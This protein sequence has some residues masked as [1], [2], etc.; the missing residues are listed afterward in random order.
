[1][2]AAP[3]PGLIHIDGR[4]VPFRE[5]QTVLQAALAA[6][7]V[8]PH[9]C[10]RPELG[11]IG[12]CRLCLVETE[13]RT[14]SACT[15]PAADGQA[16]QSD[17]PVLRKLRSALVQMLLEQGTHACTRC[18]RT[19]DCRLQGAAVEL[20]VPAVESRP[21]L[22]VSPRDDSHPQVALDRGRCILCSICIQASRQLDGKNLFAFSG[23]GGAMSLTVE[24]ASGL[25]RDS[26][27]NADDHAVR[28]CP[29]GSLTVK[30]DQAHTV[31]FSAYDFFDTEDWSG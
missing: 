5:G 3:T 18:E 30:K 29:T 9:L 20:K 7:V 12:S 10:Y 16:V 19:G 21:S 26:A 31:G 24:S 25:L 2:D 4:T 23:R 14:L 1:M 28:L 15:L 11:P 13:G 27:V 22:E 17:S 6:G 8:I